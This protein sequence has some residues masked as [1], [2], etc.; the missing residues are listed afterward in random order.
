M[1]SLRLLDETTGS[2]VSSVL[3]T[4]VFSA[5]YDVYRVEVMRDNATNGQGNLQ[6]L[7]SSGSIVSASN[8][9]FASLYM[10]THTTHNESK[11]T[12]QNQIQDAFANWS[13][14]GSVTY[15]FNPYQTDTYS[16]NLTQSHGYGGST[17]PALPMRCIGVLKQAK[18]M[19]G[20]RV[21]EGVGGTFGGVIVRT[22]G[23]RVDS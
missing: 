17:T 22:Y 7:D 13:E 9:D 3:I 2:S 4:D 20:F 21:I 15:I 8:Y 18:R 16:F 6:Y 12:N 23:V 5:D 10:Y 11:L 14:G 1:S 19:T